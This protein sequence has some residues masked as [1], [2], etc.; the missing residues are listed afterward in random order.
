MNE[1]LGTNQ[2]VDHQQVTTSELVRQFGVWQERASRSPVYIVNRGRPKFV[3]L[4]VEIMEALC[5]RTQASGGADEETAALIDAYE[6]AVVF[7]DKQ[8]IV[9]RT[10]RAA[11][12]RFTSAV[13][14]RSVDMLPSAGGVFIAG[15]VKRVLRSGTSETIQIASPDYP[16]RE[17]VVKIDATPSGCVI[18]LRDLTAAEELRDSEANRAA[19]LDAV[20]ASGR[21]A[22]FRLNSRAALIEPR[23]M[24]A[25]MTGAA[26]EHLSGTRLVALIAV[27]DRQQVSALIDQVFDQG[28]IVTA[29]IELLVNGG[30]KQ[31]VVLSLASER[32]AYRRDELAGALTLLS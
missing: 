15:A 19:L 7:V 22:T 30:R 21:T 28:G 29:D 16:E 10:N 2:L 23:P 5:S 1:P 12:A 6:E 14:G 32:G 25:S 4:S 9:T 17:L 20:E 18:V 27:S 31:R 11:R 13:E 26:L 24:L 3:L 8:A